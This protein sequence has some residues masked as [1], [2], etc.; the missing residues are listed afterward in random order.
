[1]KKIVLSSLALAGVLYAATNE[2]I[3]SLYGNIPQGAKL[4]VSHRET[5]KDLDN[6]DMV[7]LKFSQNGQSQEDIVF[8]KGNLMFPD[9][10]DLKTGKSAKDSAKSTQMEKNL[11]KVY[12]SESKA[13]II[14]LGNDPKKPTIVMFSDADCPYCRMELSQI[15]KTLKNSNVEV[16]MTSVHGKDGHAK[17]YLIYDDV[18]NAKT[19]EDKIKILRKYYDENYKP[20]LSK[21]GEANIEKAQNIANKYFGAGLT[22]VPFLID[23][24]KISK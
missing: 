24:A 1:M 18:K 21:I 20:D 23:K 7:V 16:I 4:E 8:T 3:I 12:P 15:E 22:S 6:I 2:E 13:N 19:D 14:S 5:L 9:I 11:A 17:S 10:I